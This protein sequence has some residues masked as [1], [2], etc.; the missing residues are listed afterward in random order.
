MTMSMLIRVITSTFGSLRVIIITDQNVSSSNMVYY[1]YFV[2]STRSST[3]Q[4]RDA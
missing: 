2:M 4:D 3:V 1:I